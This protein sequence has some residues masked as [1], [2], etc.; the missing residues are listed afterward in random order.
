MP[1][2]P[3]NC[4]S[5]DIEFGKNLGMR[6]VRIKTEEPI[7]IEADLTVSSLFELSKIFFYEV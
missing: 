3:K 2:V 1:K 4:A 5:H 7:G 6:T